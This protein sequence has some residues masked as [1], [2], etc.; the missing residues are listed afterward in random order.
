MGAA[1]QG[2]SWKLAAAKAQMLLAYPGPVATLHPLD[3]LLPAAPAASVASGDS[4]NSGNSGDSGAGGAAA[5][6]EPQALP[7][8]S[9]PWDGATFAPQRFSHV[10]LQ[11]RSGVRALL[12]AFLTDGLVLV[13]GVVSDLVAQ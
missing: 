5:S 9:D 12:E 11:T 2:E 10:S 6:D 3:S 7:R 1:D 8:P 13:D 4:S